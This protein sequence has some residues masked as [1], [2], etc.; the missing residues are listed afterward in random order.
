[1]QGGE[2]RTDQILAGRYRHYRGEATCEYE[3]PPEGS[4]SPT[5]TCTAAWRTKKRRYRATVLLREGV[6]NV[7]VKTG[8]INA[9]RQAGGHRRADRRGPRARGALGTRE[10]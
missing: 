8:R 4:R 2:Y 3:P 7:T 1:V 5:L 9:R 10:G 6:E